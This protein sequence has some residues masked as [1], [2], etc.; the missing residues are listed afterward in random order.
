MYWSK[1][2]EKLKQPHSNRGP[3]T[4]LRR[5]IFLPQKGEVIC[6]GSKSFLSAPLN[7]LSLIGGVGKEGIREGAAPWTRGDH[8]V[9]SADSLDGCVIAS[10]NATQPKCPS[11]STL[12][13][14][15]AS[16]SKRFPASPVVLS[17]YS[18]STSC[19]FSFVSRGLD[20]FLAPLYPKSPFMCF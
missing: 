19:F 4:M 13:S 17:A 15:I 11:D 20:S 16:S 2:Q 10:Q 8:C 9:Q 7:Y 6:H 14:L 12:L 18:Y 5:S 3:N 1:G